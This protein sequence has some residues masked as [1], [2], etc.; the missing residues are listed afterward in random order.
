MLIATD[1][2]LHTN[3]EPHRNCSM[4]AS[5]RQ[6]ITQLCLKSDLKLYWDKLNKLNHV[7]EMDIII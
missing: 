6:K 7:E 2:D 4:Y 3:L 5:N 1:K